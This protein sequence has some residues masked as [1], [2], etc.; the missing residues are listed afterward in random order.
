MR[1]ARVG[2]WMREREDGREIEVRKG[3]L[4]EVLAVRALVR[5]LHP[6][7]PLLPSS[8]HLSAAARSSQT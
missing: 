4:G 3:D 5:G 2:G 1:A 8:P 6:L 7:L